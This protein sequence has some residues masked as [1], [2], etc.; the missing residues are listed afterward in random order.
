MDSQQLAALG[1]VAATAGVFIWTKRP[2]RKFQL[3]RDT[4]CGCAGAARGG[5]KGSIVFSARKGRRP[6]IL[7]KSN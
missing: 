4:H 3:E 1:V 5:A 6:I 7:V 2:G